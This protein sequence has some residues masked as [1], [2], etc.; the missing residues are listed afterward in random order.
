MSICDF[1]KFS[2]FLRPTVGA[3]STLLLQNPPGRGTSRA[4]TMLLSRASKPQRRPEVEEGRTSLGE[5]HNA[6]ALSGKNRR[7]R[8]VTHLW[9]VGVVRSRIHRRIS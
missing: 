7:W 6:P 3:E 1:C 9:Q 8:F 5:E 2:L 4:V